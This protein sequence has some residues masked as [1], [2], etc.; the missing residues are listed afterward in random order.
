MDGKNTKNNFDK[1]KLP[2]ITRLDRSRRL[3]GM[4]Y[5]S[6]V[7]EENGPIHLCEDNYDWI[8]RLENLYQIIGWIQN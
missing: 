5:L 3:K 2:Y 8:E 4:I 6:D 1:N 7:T